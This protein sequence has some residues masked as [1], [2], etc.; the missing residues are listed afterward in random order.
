MTD[1]FRFK[2]LYLFS[3]LPT[4][5]TVLLQIFPSLSKLSQNKLDG[6]PLYLFQHYVPF[7]MNSYNFAHTPTFHHNLF[8]IHMTASMDIVS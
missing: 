3:H 8:M 7:R 5:P 1:R 6:L 4:K 2:Y